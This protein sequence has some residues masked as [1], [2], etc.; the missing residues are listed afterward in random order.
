MLLPST[1]QSRDISARDVV[2]QVKSCKF[3]FQDT[4][5]SLITTPRKENDF[6]S[7]GYSAVVHIASMEKTFGFNFSCHSQFRD[8]NEVAA[9]YGGYLK[10]GQSKWISA[11][12]GASPDEVSRLR[13]VTKTLPLISRNGRGFYTIQDETVGEPAR[14]VRHFSYCLF[15]KAQAIC[16]DGEVKRL[17]D[18]KSDMLPYALSILRNIEFIDSPSAST[19]PTNP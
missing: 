15:H 17:A 9:D 3:R 6:Q 10:P 1:A 7:A 14:R 5:E 12:P 8:E 13:K 18:T 16:G 11:F 19:K 2:L 4:L